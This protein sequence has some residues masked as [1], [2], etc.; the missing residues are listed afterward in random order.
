[1]KI[2]QNVKLWNSYNT[3]IFKISLGFSLKMKP[4]NSLNLALC[5]ACLY[6][7]FCAS[8]LYLKKPRENQNIDLFDHLYEAI[9]CDSHYV[10]PGLARG[11]SVPDFALA[12]AVSKWPEMSF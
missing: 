10:F 8:Q 11:V 3:N 12:D 4:C 5:R 9:L 2:K 6:E 1:M 7:H